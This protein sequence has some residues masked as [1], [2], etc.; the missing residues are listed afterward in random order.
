[1]AD[2]S[3]LAREKDGREI[4]GVIHA[5]NEQAAIFKIRENYPI[6]LKIHKIPG[7]KTIETILENEMGDRKF[8]AEELSILC[9]RFSVVLRSGIPAVR[10]IQMLASQ[11]SDRRL[12]KILEDAAN[13]VISGNSMASAFA[14]GGGRFSQMFIETVRAGEQSGTL[15]ESFDRLHD[16]YEKSYKTTEKVKNALMYPG[17]VIAM[18]VLVLILLM[19]KVIPVL[20]DMIEYIGGDLPLITKYMIGISDFLAEQWKVLLAAAVFL[21]I[22]FRRAVKTQKGRIWKAKIELAVP[23]LGEIRR[24]NASAQFAGTMAVLLKSGLTIDQAVDTAADAI[25]NAVFADE[26]R[27]VKDGIIQGKKMTDCF[28][29]RPYFP[30]TMIEMCSTGE[31]TGELETAFSHAAAYYANEADYRMQRVL[32]MLE[33]MLLV[34]VAVFAGFAAI[35]VYLPIFA[36]YDQM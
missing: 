4:R 23:F 32:T 9:A 36:M 26:I 2:F 12:C 21:R 5:E 29:D 18:T 33:P 24:M 16:F 10:A 30:Q 13:E 6:L 31:E 34:I 22:L 15:A 28:K 25:D 8:K 14:K 3:Y 7:N 17:F 1:M 27:S 35:S 20:T 19:V 11:C